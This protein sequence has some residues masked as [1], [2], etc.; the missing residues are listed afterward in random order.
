[1]KVV[2][3]RPELMVRESDLSNVKTRCRTVEVAINIE[4]SSPRF[5]EFLSNET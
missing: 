3:A 1:M 4:S 2:I 5:C